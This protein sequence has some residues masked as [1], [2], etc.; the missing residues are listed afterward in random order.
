MKK[1]ASSAQGRVA[2]KKVGVKRAGSK[3]KHMLGDAERKA[4]GIKLEA[5]KA[6]SAAQ[7]IFTAAD[8]LD[9]KADDLHKSI[10]ETHLR[11]HEPIAG[12]AESAAAKTETSELVVD[13]NGEAGGKPFTIVGIGASAGG[14]EAFTDFLLALPKDTG[15]AFVLIQ[16]LDPK[17]KS[18]LTDL[19]GHNAKIPVTEAAEN[20][21]VEADHIYV[22]PEN[23]TMSIHNGRLRLSPR[24]PQESPPMP[25]DHFFRSLAQEQQERAIGIVLSGTGSDGT[26]GIEA[27][28]G[29]GGIIFSQDERTAKYFGMPAN[30]IAS[31][32]VDFVLSPTDIAKELS[33]IARHPYVGRI[34]RPQPKDAAGN[35]DLEKLL[36]ERPSE[37][38]SLFTLLRVRTG[39][40]FSLYKQST[41]KR[42][43][44]RRMLLH[45]VDTLRSYLALAQGNAAEVDGLFNDLLI[46]VTSFFRDPMTFQ[47][48]K[49]KILPRLVKAHSEDSPLRFWVCGC[50]SGEE[51]YSLA[52]SLVEFSEQSYIRRQ[53][54]I[55]ATDVSDASIEKARAGIYP[56][57]F[58]KT[59]RRHAC[60]G[61]LRGRMETTKS[62]SRSAT[63]A[64]LLARTWWSTRLSRTWTW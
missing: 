28:K 47:I 7:Q 3:A 15:M 50:A 63:C 24:K 4:K 43:I 25:I 58:S 23:T 6:L 37:L 34:G 45:K 16:H 27:I 49:K 1:K 59:S 18:K 5:A 14:F 26:L 22:I 19:L 36:R 60:A 32:S 12:A 30:A 29:E 13:E 64:S 53:G 46:N 17:H 39:V 48:L 20:L 11:I 31:G 42:R 51:A 55:F 33:R 9:L 57:T 41:L 52:I 8:V 40:D 62:T 38:T 56:K 35:F 61:S 21:E 54:Q 44:I 2:K 10:H